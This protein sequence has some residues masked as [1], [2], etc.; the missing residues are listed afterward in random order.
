MSNGAFVSQ[1]FE[2]EGVSYIAV[3][4]STSILKDVTADPGGLSGGGDVTTSLTYEWADTDYQWNTGRDL[5]AQEPFFASGTHFD[6]DQ[7]VIKAALMERLSKQKELLHDHDNGPESVQKAHQYGV[8]Q[9]YVPMW[10][11]SYDTLMDVFNELTADKSED[12]ILKANVFTEVL[13]STGTTASAMVVRDLVKDGKFDNARDAART[14]T[15]VPY[16]IRRPN[17]DLVAEFE[18]LLTMDLDDYVKTAAHLSLGHLVRMTCE[19]AGPYDVMKAC[20]MEHG[21]KYAK[22]FYDKF[23]SSTDREEKTM[24]MGA[25]SNIRYGGLVEILTPVMDGTTGESSEFRSFAVWA[26]FSEAAVRKKAVDLYLPVYADRNNDHEVRIAAFNAFT[27]SKPT[28]TDMA[29]AVAVLRTEKDYELINFVFARLESMAG[30]IS[31]C[32]RKSKSIAGFFLKYLKQFSRYNT[33][34]GFGVSKTYQRQFTK[35]KYGYSGTYSFTTVGAHDSTTP[36]SIGM[37]ISTTLRQTYVANSFY[38]HFRIEGLA[39]GLIRKFKTMDPAAWKTADLEKILTG[40]M[41][42]AARQSQPVRVSVMVMVK[43]NIALVR[44]YQAGDSGEGGKLEGFLK[45]L[46]GIGSDINHQ[47]VWKAAFFMQEQPTEI[48]LPATFGSS[49]TAMFSLKASGERKQNRG[50]IYLDAKYNIHMF[51]QATNLMIVHAL[52]AKQTYGISQDRVYHLHIPRELVVGVNPPRK[53]LK[54][55]VSRPEQD[56]PAMFMMHAQ[57]HVH[58]RDNTLNSAPNMQLVSR[59]PEA[60]VKRTIFDR[61]NSKWGY[62]AKAE[63]FDCEMDI[64]RR[65]TLK[66]IFGAFMPYNKNPKTPWTSVMMGMRQ[67]R[68][69]LFL[70][71]RAEK[72]GIYASWSQSS[73]NPVRKLELSVRGSKED[74]GERLFLRGRKLQI[75]AVLKAIGDNTRA[76]RMTVLS[77]TSPGGLTNKLKVEIDRAKVSALDIKPYSIC[78]AYLAKYPPFSKQMFDVDMNRDLKMS[79][80]AQLKYGEGEDCDDAEGVVNVAFEYST[81]AEAR[82]SLK[83]KWYYQSCMDTKKSPA[84]QH[85]QGLPISEPCYMTAYDASNARKYKYDIKFE[86][87]SV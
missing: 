35:A 70:F 87:V 82:E 26:M 38:F 37:G 8:N 46:K 57:T 50:L 39:K 54:L 11:M 65:N 20:F 9:L 85:R 72:C 51:T 29:R 76:Y 60:A 7:G 59:G 58:I 63:Y 56:H 13:S 18:K 80:K 79:G 71:P 68:A 15:S 64:S 77:E 24:L 30:S 12:G 61:D 22:K 44:T 36:L 10:A 73:Q 74:Q 43:G 83:K 23:A 49:M 45:R 75:K 42:I 66:N 4:N 19:R 6:E 78:M 16:H 84:W 53:E 31:P 17:L 27:M 52:G 3:V 33:D 48:G 5:K 14:L 40:D 55:S 81:T 25:I 41:Q 32:D 69:F 2:T 21:S 47:R 34:W 86:K 62:K 1:M 67:V 28:T